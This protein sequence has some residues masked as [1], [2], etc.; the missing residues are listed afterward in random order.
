MLR[1]T[2]YTN[3]PQQKTH[4]EHQPNQLILV[5]FLDSAMAT[6]LEKMLK[7][8]EGGWNRVRADDNYA[9]PNCI[10]SVS[11][12]SGVVPAKIVQLGY[13]E[14]VWVALGVEPAIRLVEW[15]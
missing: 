4:L 10:R 8:R 13:I 1:L 7:A 9:D 6:I 5:E 15:L 12:P 2:P 3:R 14:L 11:T